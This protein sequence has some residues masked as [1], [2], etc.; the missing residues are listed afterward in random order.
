MALFIN[1]QITGSVTRRYT[2]QVPDNPVA[3]VAPAIVVFHGGGQDVENIALRWGVDGVNPV[4]AY[5]ADYL[6][7]FP[8]SD[9]RMGDRWVHFGSGDVAF[10]TLD[11]EFVTQLLSELITRPYP[12]AVAGVTVSADPEK[13]Y[14]AGFSSGAG[15]MWNLL[16]SDL[17]PQIRGFAAVGQPLTPE[18]VR[19]YRNQLAPALPV[20][21]PVAY[22]QG[23]HDTFFR[24]PVSLEELAAVAEGAQDMTYP[25]YTLREMLIRNGYPP[26]PPWPAAR[27]KELVPGSQNSTE[28]VT[29]LFDGG[30]EAFLFVTVVH[31]GH[32]WPTPTT[33][34]K[35]P[36][37]QHFDATDAIIR[38]WQAHAGL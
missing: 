19:R 9:P 4:P 32:N 7:V 1:E 37:A 20:A 2:I 5:L 13:I 16:N 30:T 10:P 22:I 14:A 27:T 23:T 29:Q 38:F 3:T 28:V 15:M 8:E 21:A 35:P 24:P 33:L 31:G 26:P 25:A 6:L 17:S 18:K 36:V 34:A 11:L 12:T